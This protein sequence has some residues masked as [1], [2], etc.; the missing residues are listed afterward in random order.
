MNQLAEN[1]D[2]IN[3]IWSIADLLRGDYKQSEYGKVILPLVVL[4]RL[5]CVLEETKPAVLAE[6]EQLKGTI[7]NLEKVLCHV[8]GQ[9][10]YNTSKLDFT[11]LLDD[12]ERAADNLRAYI[13]AFSPG[14]AEVLSRF[15]FD[16]QITKLD[17]AGL[18][19]MVLGRFAQVDLH[20]KVVDSHSMGYIY[21]ELI[22]KFSEQSN[23][24]AGEHFTPREVIQLMVE[25]LMAPDVEQLKVPGFA[26]TIYDPACGTG[27]MLSVAEAHLR[28]LNGDA[29]PEVFGQEL[30]DETW[31]ICRSDM[32][33][34]GQDPTHIAVGNTLTRDAFGR[35]TFNYMLSNPPFGVEWKKIEKDIRDE[36]TKLG[37]D[38]RFGAGLPRVSDGSLLFLQHMVSKMVPAEQGGSRIAIV[39]NGSPL[40]TGDAGSGESEIRRWLIENDWLEAVVGLPEDLF[41]NTSI[42]TYF[43]L[44]TNRKSPSRRG[45]V[46]LIDA[47]DS[48]SKMRRPLG[49]KRKEI[50]PHQIAEIV[51]LYRE[52][53][54][55][56][57]S[58]IVANEGLGYQRVPVSRPLRL[59]YSGRQ[60]WTR[61]SGLSGLSDED[62][63]RVVASEPQVRSIS[64][65]DPDEADRSLAKLGISPAGRRA[66][67]ARMATR[68]HT[69]PPVV[70]K[71][72]R[73]AD[74]DFKTFEKVPLPPLNGG[75][76]DPRERVQS[77]VYLALVARHMER[78]VMPYWPDAWADATKTRIGYEIPFT[79][80]F[81]RYTA[82][83]ALSA[84]DADIAALE[85]DIQRVLEQVID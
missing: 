56:P 24:T 6:Y 82:P 46:Q 4:R 12:P 50:A 78:E 42:A 16:E 69:A 25:L 1:S 58:R 37:D 68:D 65:T 55:S 41:Y 47:R 13:G 5:D 7:S 85:Q 38:G 32:M 48:W 35:K 21:E 22:R 19:Y 26:P 61:T 74:P 18:L 72:R 80:I 23:E 27:G 62:A 30:N 49:E 71:G 44:V 39:F 79:R 14:A 75:N 20:P 15:G 45:K 73:E 43:W 67:L 81:H 66:M 77:E 63:D 52:F 36:H 76:P 8:S 70:R 9:A 10:F 84:I 2:R 33:L 3:F 29:R 64:T 54:D 53:E 83:R 11:R 40:F 28:D 60:E 34:K 51:S 31:A 59:R 17:K 57:R